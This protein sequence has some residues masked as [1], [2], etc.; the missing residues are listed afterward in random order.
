MRYTNSV[1]THTQ[2]PVILL[3]DPPFI[4]DVPSFK[5]PLSSDRFSQP[6]TVDDTGWHRIKSPV[7]RKKTSH[8]V[9]LNHH[10]IPYEI[11]RKSYLMPLNAYQL[12]LPNHEKSHGELD[13]NT[14]GTFRDWL[15]VCSPLNSASFVFKVSWAR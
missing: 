15:R 9:P 14:R 3:E 7:N 13:P 4:Y 1:Y 8:K 6:T 10:E 2:L 12:S 5:P 11:S